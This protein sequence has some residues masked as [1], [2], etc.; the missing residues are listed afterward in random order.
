MN[1]SGWR[2]R[3]SVGITLVGILGVYLALDSRLVTGEDSYTNIEHGVDDM[4]GA[5]NL[6]YNDYVKE[7]KPE[8]LSK[9]AISGMLRDLDPYTSFF[10]RKALEQLQIDTRGNFGGLGITITKRRQDNKPPVVMSVIEGTPADTSG[11][12]V[13]D[14]IVMVEGDSTHAKDLSKV[15]EVL[16]GRPGEGVTITIERPG[17]AE[18]FDQPIIRA[19]IGIPSVMVPGEI[20]PEIGYISMSELNSGRFTERTS[21]ELERALKA[22][23]ARKPKG[24]ILDL[25]GNPGGLLNSAVDVVD[26][27][28]GPGHVVVTTKG[29]RPEQSRSE[30]TKTAAVVPKDIPLVVLVNGHSAS[31][32]EIVAGAIQDWDRGLIMGTQTFGKGSVQ[33]VRQLGADQALKLTTAAYYTPS[34]RSIHN[35]SRRNYRG[36]PIELTLADS[37][38]VSVYE[39]LGIIAGTERREEAITELGERFEMSPAQAEEALD[40]RMDRLLGLGMRKKSSGPENNDPDEVFHT[41]IRKRKVYGGGGIKP[42]VVVEVD[43]R[44]RVWVELY[45]KSL[46]FD[47]AVN[48]AANRTF[49]KRYEDYKLPADLVNQFWTYVAD[50][51]NANGF[52]YKA[53]TEIQLRELREALKEKDVFSADDEKALEQL[54]NLGEKERQADY[55]AAEASIRLEIERILAR[56]V[57]GTKA[58]MLASL[59]GDKQFKEAVQL[60]K[61]RADYD[62]KLAMIEE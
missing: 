31:A 48:Y 51:T 8:D 14:R 49:P 21:S 47:F 1:R 38:R 26:K 9:S 7:L 12:Q 25:R 13:G 17:K 5:Y 16:R 30:E 52:D 44:S 42:D 54:A 62:K 53:R 24:L 60:L 50:L 6:L 43:R 27:F 45:Q 41:R 37:M 46:F 56:R 34:G 40:V 19:R 32:S 55:K 58:E 59:K 22:E 11:L 20:D 10:D 3:F 23:L 15:V 36:G 29:R 61:D 39:L 28:L 18:W 35:A 33:T 57:W 2:R 4:V